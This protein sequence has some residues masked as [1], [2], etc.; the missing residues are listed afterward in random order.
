MHEPDF[1]I[2]AA[3]RS[4]TTSLFNYLAQHPEI[5]MSSQKEPAF[6][7]F[8]YPRPDFEALARIHGEERFAESVS[9]YE[10]TRALAV[11]DG[12][13]YHDLWTD[14]AGTRL[15]GEAT[16]TYLYD[17]NA[18][19]K[20]R[21]SRPRAKLVL[22][23]RNPTDRAYSQYLQYLRHGFES[24]YSFEEA[25][26]REPAD[27]ED[28]WWGMRRY[29]R[30]GLYADH[31]DGCLNG[32]GAGRVGV[33]L[34]ENFAAAPEMVVGEI[35]RFL[36]IDTPNQIETSLRH[37]QAFVP[38]PG[39]AVRIARSEGRLKAVARLLLPD[40]LRNRLHRRI[41]YRRQLQPPPILIETRKRLNSFFE[42]G[43][44]R[45]EL[46]L[47]RDLSIWRRG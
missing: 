13:S 10:Q 47:D 46:L 40:P 14:A 6:F 41:I 17:A 26:Q 5:Q 2:A 34:Y 42:P 31:V 3:P 37:K 1:F 30:M 35:I 43:I 11:T 25:L 21:E 20:L 29:L 12:A 32:F 33:F 15:R 45:L 16:P 22:L 28:F 38:V 9:H 8:T 4:G 19:E 18:L 44:R 27:V 23:L 36:G 24:T 7:H 39:L